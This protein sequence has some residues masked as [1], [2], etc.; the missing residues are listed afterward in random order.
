MYFS[1]PYFALWYETDVNRD[2]FHK[3]NQLRR[4]MLAALLEADEEGHAGFNFAADEDGWTE[5][6]RGELSATGKTLEALGLSEIVAET[7]GYIGLKITAEGLRVASDPRELARRLPVGGAED[8]EIGS[9]IVSDVMQPLI[10]DCEQLLSAR[11]WTDALT[12]LEEGDT[13]F[14][15]ERWRDAIREYYRAVGSGLKYRL[16]ERDVRY[17]SSTALR[18]LASVAV[19][20]GLIPRNY[21]ALFS[22]LDSIR[23]PKSHGGGPTPQDAGGSPR[24]TSDGKRRSLA[25]ALPRRHSDVGQ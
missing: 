7:T 21:Q 4:K 1:T 3:R 22:F 25:V 18:Q 8:A 5:H 13:A 14:E 12:E 15:E 19:Q 24:G 6:S 16:N 17:G 2:E 10:L 20:A 9:K 11:G 23:S